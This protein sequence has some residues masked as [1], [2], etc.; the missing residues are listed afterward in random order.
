MET[1]NRNNSEKFDTFYHKTVKNADKK[2]ALKCRRNGKTQTWKKSPE[3]FKIPVK[4]GLYEYFY[5][6]E[7]N[8]QDWESE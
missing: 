7:N 6:D 8:C 2:T 1:I 5:I 3:R 4:Y